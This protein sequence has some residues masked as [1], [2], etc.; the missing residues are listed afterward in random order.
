MFG[1]RDGR[2][3][4]NYDSRAIRSIVK[5]KQTADENA[6]RATVVIHGL[7]SNAASYISLVMSSIPGPT[8]GH[9]DGC[10]R[11]YGEQRHMTI[12]FCT[13]VVSD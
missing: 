11:K 7:A 3:C 6:R 5:H 10:Y 4:E 8:I 9:V 2:V 12:A 1:A 13:E